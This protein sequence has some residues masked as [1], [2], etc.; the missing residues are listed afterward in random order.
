[1]CRSMRSREGEMNRVVPIEAIEKQIVA[2]SGQNVGDS[3]A[4]SRR[5]S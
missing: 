1:M 2:H 5:L 4:E 3:E